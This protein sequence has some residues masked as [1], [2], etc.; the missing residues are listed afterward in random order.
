MVARRHR[1]VQLARARH[2]LTVGRDDDRR[3]EAEA[4][5]AV[6]ALV[7]RGVHVHSRLGGHPSGELEGGAARQVLGLGPRRLR[8][9]R[10]GREVAAE[11][12][13][14]QADELRPLLGRAADARRERLLVL[15]GIGVPALL[16]RADPKRRAPGRALARRRDVPAGRHDQ[17]SLLC[18]PS[19]CTVVSR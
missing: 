8:T 13:L 19:E 11:R 4:V 2:E 14:L 9:A 18:H 6:G 15:L 12:E 10:V 3:V 17:M 7:Q 16:H 5:R 1:D